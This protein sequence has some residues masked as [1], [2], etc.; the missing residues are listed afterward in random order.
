MRALSTCI[1]LSTYG[2]LSSTLALPVSEDDALNHPR[3]LSLKLRSDPASAVAPVNYIAPRGR[4]STD[5]VIGGQDLTLLIDTG[6]E[7]L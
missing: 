6:S 3:S 4:W 7:A 1:L 5:F 2:L